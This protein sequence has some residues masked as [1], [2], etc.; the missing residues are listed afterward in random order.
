M[1]ALRRRASSAINQSGVAIVL[2]LIFLLA[3]APL[4]T[5]LLVNLHTTTAH[6]TVVSR[7]LEEAYQI[8]E[9]GINTTIFRAEAMVKNQY[10]GSLQDF[11][12]A[13]NGFIFTDN[14]FNGGSYEAKIE[15]PLT[16][17][18]DSNYFR[19][20]CKG[21]KTTRS[22][23]L[24]ALIHGPTQPKAFDYSLY[25]N[26]VHFDNHN[27]KPFAI[28]MVSSI[29]SNSSIFVDGG[30]IIDGPLIAVEDIKP[31][32]GPACNGN[33][34]GLLPDTIFTQQALQGNPNP[35]P[36][37]PTA[38]VTTMSPM[39]PVL[40]FPTFDF[41][42]ARAL[43]IANGTYFTPAQFQDLIKNADLYAR[44]MSG[45][46]SNAQQ[47]PGAQYP[48]GV[49]VPDVPV[50][51]V[52]HYYSQ[53]YNPVTNSLPR[54]VLA[55]T[56]INPARFVPLGSPDGLRLPTT[57]CYEIV[58]ED[59]RINTG[60]IDQVFYVDGDLVLESIDRNTLVRI[61]G[62]LIVRGK[63]EI[64]A[65]LE[66]LAWENKDLPTVVPL[67]QTLYNFLPPVGSGVDI[68]Y[69]RY[70]VLAASDAL[71]IE[72]NDKG[73]VHIEG[74]VY[75]TAEMHLHHDEPADAIYIAGNETADIMHVCQYASLFYDPEARRVLGFTN[76]STFRTDMS[77]VRLDVRK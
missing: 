45:I 5:A 13:K 42:R 41:A 59:N 69:S 3:I 24:E 7:T 53:P 10:G 46:K 11:L 75:S 60:A 52:R 61:E 25:G 30:V 14:S 19:I 74:V 50:K 67:N 44:S 18:G 26:F 62:S 35:T 48:N 70:P 9:A 4:I 37:V 65:A 36:L 68:R 40:P 8:A 16:I 47:L 58:L 55:P 64:R 20:I 27:K 72:Q 71:K 15:G 2:V 33:C 57:S 34:K 63:C 17:N 56:P 21:T 22:R 54:A 77:I 1:K 32:T 39:P 51:V 31:N 29:Y 73:P 28:T 66:L 38:P 76:R 6:F 43:A 12:A 23:T 49:S